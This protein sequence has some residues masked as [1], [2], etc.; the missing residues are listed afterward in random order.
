MNTLEQLKQRYNDQVSLPKEDKEHQ[1]ITEV[2]GLDFTPTTLSAENYASF[3]QLYGQYAQLERVWVKSQKSQLRGKQLSGLLETL[4]RL[5]NVSDGNS[6]AKIKLLMEFGE[7][8][9]D[10]YQ[11]LLTN[12]QD[13][14]ASYIAF[15]KQIK[16][17]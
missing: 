12:I 3:C 6:A 9:P 11:G 14:I 4:N 10:H 2:L 7:T 16:V 15:L 8:R 13:F 1:F 17:S 5:R